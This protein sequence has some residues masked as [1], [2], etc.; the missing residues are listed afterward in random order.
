MEKARVFGKNR[1][2]FSDGHNTLIPWT[3]SV[4]KTKGNREWGMEQGTGN[5]EQGTGEVFSISDD[6]ENGIESEKNG[7]DTII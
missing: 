2:I 5:R 7:T 1:W 6:M 4:S 3:F